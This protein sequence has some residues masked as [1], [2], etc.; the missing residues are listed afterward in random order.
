MCYFS[1]HNYRNQYSLPSLLLVIISFLRIYE[2]Q[3]LPSSMINGY[4]VVRNVMVTHVLSKI[5]WVSYTLQQYL[6]T[7]EISEIETMFLL[8]Y[9]SIR[10][11]SLRIYL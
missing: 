9:E 5:V 10:T 1:L 3:W 8:I 11:I 6:H 4:S 7:Y 2:I